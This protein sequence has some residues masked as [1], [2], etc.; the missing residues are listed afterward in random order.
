MS[1]HSQSANTKPSLPLGKVVP[2]PFY[3]A[4]QGPISDVTLQDTVGIILAQAHGLVVAI[5][6]A[7]FEQGCREFHLEEIEQVLDVLREYLEKG[8]AIFN[9]WAESTETP[10]EPAQPEEGPA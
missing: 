5:R 3:S 8:R 7:L 6:Y 9:A 4:L 2:D 1:R 10:G